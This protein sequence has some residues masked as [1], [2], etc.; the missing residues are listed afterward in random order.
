MKYAK[1]CQD[2]IL[3]QTAQDVADDRTGRDS[4]D[5]IPHPVAREGE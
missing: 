2:G 4:L 5:L 3:D 1:Y